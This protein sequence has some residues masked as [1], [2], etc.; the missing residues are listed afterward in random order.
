MSG[1]KVFFDT[2]VLVYAQ[3]LD[4]P[5]KRER[6]RQLMAEVAAAGGG[7]ISTQVLQEYYVTAT[8]KLGVT[9]LAAK[10]VVQSFR[11][12]EIVQL[13]PDLIEQA[14]DRSVLSQLSFWDALIVAASAASG[15]TTIYSEDLNAGQVIGGVRVVNPFG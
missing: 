4:A 3:D 7:V 8:R 1:G 5:H 15:C 2:N 10:S 6:S 14:I 12:F 9:P 11:M 13:S